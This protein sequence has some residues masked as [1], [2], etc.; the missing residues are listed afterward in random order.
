MVFTS[1]GHSRLASNKTFT[2]LS[3]S[4]WIFTKPS[5]ASTLAFFPSSSV[6]LALNRL[7]CKE[8]FQYSKKNI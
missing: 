4:A 5:K 6:S 3:N 7:F 8:T 2:L 1:A